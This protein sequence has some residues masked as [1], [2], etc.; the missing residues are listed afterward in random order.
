[1][2]DIRIYDVPLTETEIATLYR[3]TKRK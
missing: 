2:D 1:M 3:E